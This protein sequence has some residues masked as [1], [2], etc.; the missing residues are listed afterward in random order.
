MRIFRHLSLGAGY[1]FA[2]ISPAFAAEFQLPQGCTAY[3]TMQSKECYA[4]HHYTCEG[5]PAGYQWR[6]DLNADGPVFVSQIDAETR[7]VYSYE[8]FANKVERLGLNSKDPASLTDLLETGRN[9][10]DFTLFDNEGKEVRV[11]GY[12]ALVG[13]E[14]TIDG[15]TLLQTEHEVTATNAAGEME[16]ASTGSEYVSPEFR[17]FISGKGIWST[18]EGDFENDSTPIEF[19]F[20]DEAGFLADTPKYD[21]DSVMSHLNLEGDSHDQI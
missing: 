1:V 7:W 13:P 3:L 21:C 12:D 2:A 10:F 9:E 4:S 15:V 20:P 5:D 6:V 19:V 16:W 17:M 8:I 11:V 14:V 18:P